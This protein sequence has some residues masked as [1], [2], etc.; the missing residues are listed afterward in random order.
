M[1]LE[2]EPAWTFTAKKHLHMSYGHV[3]LLSDSVV[4]QWFVAKRIGGECLWEKEFARVNTIFEITDDVI[5][6][7]ETRSDGPW[8][9]D[10]GCYGISLPN[11][12]MLW[13]WYGEGL[14]GKSTAML[15]VV[16]GLTNELRPHFF[17][18]RGKE[19]ATKDGHIL[20]VHTGKLLRHEAKITI[21]EKTYGPQTA[22]QK[23][24]RGQSIEIDQNRLL[25]TREARMKEEK[26]SNGKTRVIHLKQTKPFGFK[27]QDAQ[28]EVMW[29]WSPTEIGLHPKENYYGWRLIE[30]KLL[31]LCS[32]EPATVP[33]RLDKPR[34]VKPNSA[35]YHLLL[36]DAL[37]GKVDQNLVVSKE[38][39]DSCRIEDV[40]G[41][42]VLVS[43]GERDLCY[44][45]FTA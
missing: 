39:T 15:D 2:S 18:V 20:D 25:S 10:F 3:H 5:L 27:L 40:D 43:H 7:S 17:G 9:L 41:R 28:G 23:I 19:C 36:V 8:T 11:G 4:G 6:A 33:I 30:N 22:A 37:T 35:I 29:D 21:P 42:G 14:R 16:P 12:E 1:V 45:G 26:L 32:E 24:Y 34:I 38:K 44:Y 31:L 13:K